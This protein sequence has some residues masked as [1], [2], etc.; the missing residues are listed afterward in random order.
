MLTRTKININD[1]YR[2]YLEQTELPVVELPIVE[3]PLHK[4]LYWYVW[5]SPSSKIKDFWIIVNLSN[6]G[7]RKEL[8]RYDN[9]F[10]S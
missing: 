6:V 2:R 4:E 3:P 1:I 5:E 9:A 10:K 7:Q 8:T